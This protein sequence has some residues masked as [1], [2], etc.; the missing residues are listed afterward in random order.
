[1]NIL[2][3]P[4]SFKYVDKYIIYIILCKQIYLWCSNQDVA[5]F[6]IISAYKGMFGVII[7]PLVS[8]MVPSGSIRSVPG[9]SKNDLGVTKGYKTG[10][11][12][13]SK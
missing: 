12:I 4:K 5:F 11:V 1:M 6:Y 7:A 10:R 3:W 8:A 9:P 13:L 2:F